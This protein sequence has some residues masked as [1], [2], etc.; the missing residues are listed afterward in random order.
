MPEA[1]ASNGRKDIDLGAEMR[2]FAYRSHRLYY[3]LDRTGILVVRNL[4][5]A[6]DIPRAMGDVRD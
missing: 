4:H 6:R 2:S 5:H 3:R 1:L